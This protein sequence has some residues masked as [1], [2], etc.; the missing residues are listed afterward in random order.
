VIIDAYMD[1]S[2]THGASPMMTIG[3][4]VGRLSQWAYF[5]R[6]WAK[7]LKKR[8]IPYFHSKSLM[9]TQRPFRGW[10]LNQKS[11]L[12]IRAGDIQK[13]H[14]MFGFSIRLSR[15]DY[16]QCYKSGERPKKIPLDTM[17]GLCFRYVAVWLPSIIEV[18]LGTN[19]FEINFIMEAGHK[20]AGDALRVFKQ[21]NKDAE[22]PTI[23]RSLT[24]EDKKSL[25]GLQGADY[26]AH[27]TW[28]VENEPNIETDHLTDFPKNGTVQDAQKIL[29][30]KSPVFRGAFVPDL[31]REIKA[32]TMAWDAKRLEFGRRKT[33]SE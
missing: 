10:T 12:I 16:E 31:L 27:T 26:V 32:N 14:T 15:S 19:E 9:D 3:G 29:G 17:Y 8:G 20:N 7:M 22:K 11:D 30:R 24:F 4:L 2:G 6:R 5:D 28:L 25:Y 13:K 23:F 18:S 33:H 21:I 1:E